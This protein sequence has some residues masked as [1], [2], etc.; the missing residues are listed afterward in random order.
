MPQ[1]GQG[2]IYGVVLGTVYWTELDD[3]VG[4][5]GWTELRRG[6]CL[7]LTGE[8]SCFELQ[9]LDGAVAVDRCR[10][11]DGVVNIQ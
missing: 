11:L 4:T 10:I 1:V 3:V 9:K 5:S 7:I 8:E 6:I 2:I